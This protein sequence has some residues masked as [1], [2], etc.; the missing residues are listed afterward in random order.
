MDKIQSAL[1][2]SVGNISPT[3]AWRT[4]RFII[5]MYCYRDE[6]FYIYCYSFL[7]VYCILYYYR[8]L[9]YVQRFRG[10][11]TPIFYARTLR[12]T[13]KKKKNKRNIKISNGEKRTIFLRENLR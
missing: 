1:Y 3:H 8:Q 5:Q 10:S 11:Y 4:F 12:N 13:I 6:K 9:L 2:H 7:Q